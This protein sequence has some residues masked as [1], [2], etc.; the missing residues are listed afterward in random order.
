MSDD[1]TVKGG[2]GRLIRKAQVRKY[3]MD[4]IARNRARKFSR[5]AESV[6]DEADAALRA[7]CRRKADSLPSIGM[8]VK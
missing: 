4:Y 8:T 2:D 5:V 1:D 3:L 7:W 6:Y